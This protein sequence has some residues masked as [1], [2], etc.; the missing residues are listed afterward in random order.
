[1]KRFACGRQGAPF[2]M[3]AAA[4]HELVIDGEIAVPDD[5]GVTRTASSAHPLE[6]AVSS[7]GTSEDQD[8]CGS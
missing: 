1:V 3:L 6:F 4:G 5:R 7:V 8:F 2:S